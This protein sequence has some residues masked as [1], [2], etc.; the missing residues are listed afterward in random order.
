MEALDQALK[1]QLRDGLAALGQDPSVYPWDS[2]LAYLRL[3]IKWGAAYNLVGTRDPKRLVSHH[4]LD[5]LS[6]LEFVKGPRAL[7]IGTGAGLPGLI[8]ALAH[9]RVRWTLVDSNQKKVR[10]LNQVMQE[11]KPAN[12]EVVRARAQEFSPEAR[13]NT[14]VSR[15]FGSVAE[16]VDVARPLLAQGGVMLAMKGRAPEVEVTQAP[17][18]ELDVTVHPL[19]VPG[20]DAERSVVLLRTAAAYGSRTTGDATVR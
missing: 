9:P 11:L 6:I 4:I 10:F 8:L 2:Y 19:S 16:F 18:P 13:F 3:L 15:A 17:M 14:V 5:S 20:V 12:V 7:D 1:T